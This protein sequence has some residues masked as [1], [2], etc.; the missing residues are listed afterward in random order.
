LI[1]FLVGPGR[2]SDEYAHSHGRKV[3]EVMTRDVRTIAED[4]SLR[5]VIETMEKHGIKR[6]PV[7]RGGRLV[8]IVTRANLMRALASLALVATPPA[9]DDTEIRRSILDEMDKQAWRLS[10]RSLLRSR[11]A[12]SSCPASS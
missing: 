10:R 11:M 1:E 4:T 9:K 2:L 3:Q 12:S 8:G 7:L 6:L 5:E